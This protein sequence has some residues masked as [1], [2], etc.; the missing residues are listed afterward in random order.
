LFY[1][2]TTYNSGPRVERPVRMWK[3][4]SLGLLLCFLPVPA[5]AIFPTVN[6]VGYSEEVSNTVTHNVT[7]PAT[8]INGELML[9]L[10]SIDGNPTLSGMQAGW[11]QRKRLVAAGNT[12][13]IEVWSI[14]Y[15]GESAFTYTSSASERSENR[16]LG[17]GS[18]HGSAAPEVST[19]AVGNSTTPDPDSLT[20]SWGAE[21]T[22]WVAFAGSD[23]AVTA[24]AFPT[25]YSDNQ[26][27]DNTGNDPSFHMATRELNASSEDPGTF[28]TGSQ[29]WATVTIGVRPSTA[30][31]YYFSNQ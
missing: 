29:D 3:V 15:N 28:T 12:N 21:D 20:P 9:L 23:G 2:E 24:S 1:T 26:F 7:Y 5:Y 22:L 13:T 18:W 6:D 27:T 4:I 25:N 8:A 11:T 14:V 19:G 30:A 31:P 10:I 17:I 16:V